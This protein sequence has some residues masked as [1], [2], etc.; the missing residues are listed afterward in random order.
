MILTRFT[1]LVVK[2]LYLCLFSIK[3]ESPRSTLFVHI[4][5]KWYRKNY[6][7]YCEITLFYNTLGSSS[8][9]INDVPMTFSW[10]SYRIELKGTFVHSSHHKPVS[11]INLPLN[12]SVRLTWLFVEWQYPL[13]PSKDDP[14]S[15][16]INSYLDSQQEE[17]HPSPFTLKIN[18]LKYI[19]TNSRNGPY[20]WKVMKSGQG[21]HPTQTQTRRSLSG[22]C[23]SIFELITYLC[24]KPTLCLS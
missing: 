24:P 14:W 8:S 18:G 4:D 9:L 5:T 1:S 19:A 15:P 16:S 3:N 21:V 12:P 22:V 6:R 23:F 17:L 11:Q 13:P 2:P 7:T 10:R 20:N